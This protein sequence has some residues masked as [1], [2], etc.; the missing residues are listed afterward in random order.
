MVIWHCIND[1]VLILAQAKAPI[2]RMTD[3][4][5]P[6]LQVG[7]LFHSDESLTAEKTR[8]KMVLRRQMRVAVKP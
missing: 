6:T 5:P 1:S 3:K 4:M 7:A 2:K 8:L